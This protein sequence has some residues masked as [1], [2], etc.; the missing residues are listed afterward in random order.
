MSQMEKAVPAL[1]KLTRSI[2]FYYFIVTHKCLLLNVEHALPIMKKAL[3]TSLN[4]I[5]YC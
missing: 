5:Y 3:L 1:D 4:R 2:S